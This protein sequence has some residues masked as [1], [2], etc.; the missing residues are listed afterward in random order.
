VF[1]SNGGLYAA[2]LSGGTVLT[3]G[4]Q[5]AYV[6]LNITRL[7]T[8]SGLYISGTN[9]YRFSARFSQAVEGG[10]QVATATVGTGA[11]EVSVTNDP[12]NPS[13]RAR[14]SPTQ[15][16][17]GYGESVF[18]ARL[19]VKN[20]N[21]AT[22]YTG[23]FEDS[24]S[25]ALQGYASTRVNLTSGMVAVTG[26]LP[27][28][29]QRFAASA[30]MYTDPAGNSSATMA[31]L[32]VRLNATKQMFATWELESATIGGNL[33]IVSA[34]VNAASKFGVTGA[35]YAPAAPGALLVPFVSTRDQAIVT[36]G[37]AELARF[38][39]SGNR[40]L[41]AGSAFAP[42]GG[43]F[44]LSFNS[45]T[46]VVSGLISTGS[47]GG[48]KAFSG[49]ILQGDYR[50]NGGVIGVAILPATGETLRFE[51]AN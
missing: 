26:L 11:L 16:A 40:L 2:R 48:A 43:R 45:A 37:A 30:E 20:L 41:P 17:A 46:G 25:G 32:I 19:G 1:G 6:R 44:S 9:L 7:G 8:M 15:N 12:V 39:A 50:S 24:G 23:S 31:N 28:T 14:F 47:T 51:P 10:S 36:L 22:N 27:H 42:S 18:L 4:P 33:S 34:G 38:S 3:S 49:V 5:E 35:K 13:V 21:L 29:A